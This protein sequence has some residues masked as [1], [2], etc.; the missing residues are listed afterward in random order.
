MFRKRGALSA[1]ESWTYYDTPIEVVN[2][3]NYLGRVFYY[4]GSFELHYE[5]STGKAIKALNVLLNNCKS[6][7]VKPKILCKLF[8]A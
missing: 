2:D 5:Y 3:F 6:V 7:Q 1:T 4:T 8:D